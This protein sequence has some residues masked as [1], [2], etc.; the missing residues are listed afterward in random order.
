MNMTVSELAARIGAEL[1]GGGAGVAAG[2]S[3]LENIEQD[4]VVYIENERAAAALAGASPAAVIC[5]LKDSVPGFTLLRAKNP[6]LSFAR[7]LEVFHPK[8]KPEAG[9]HPAAV[10]EAGAEIAASASIGALCFVGASAKVGEGTVLSPGCHIGAGAVVGKDCLLHPGAKVLDG[11][12]LGDRVIL[13]ANVVIGGD[14]FGYVETPEGRIKIPQVGNVVIEDDVEIGANSA[15]DRATMG[16]TRIG[17]G[18]KIDN[19]VQ[20]GHNVEI[21]ANS[22]L[23]GQAGI[24]GSSTLGAGVVLAGQVGV[25]D[26]IKIGDG[27]VLGGKA[28]VSSDVP[29]GVFYSGFPARPHTETLRIFAALKKLPELVRE[30]NRLK[31]AHEKEDAGDKD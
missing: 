28:G 23:C 21:G 22:V 16:T 24:A 26:H 5:G 7:A 17:R 20:V 25:G 18:T 11:C 1:E 15:V 9:A 30:V 27:A 29:D 8:A 10:V 31:K 19:L 13:Q 6:K 3:G 14:G 2:V 12:S 4:H